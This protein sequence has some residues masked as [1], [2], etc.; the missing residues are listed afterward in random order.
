MNQSNIILTDYQPRIAK[1]N[2]LW[3]K[4]SNA[5]TAEK[6]AEYL[7]FAESL[8]KIFVE[9]KSL[10]GPIWLKKVIFGQFKAD[11]RHPHKEKRKISRF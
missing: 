11:Q 6:I 10:L 2:A 5:E 8:N 7:I 3:T 4:L 9:F 1:Q